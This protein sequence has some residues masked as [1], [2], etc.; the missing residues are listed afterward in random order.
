MI[1]PKT[2][3]DT[4]GVFL[5]QV[6]AKA[7]K[8]ITKFNRNWIRCSEFFAQICNQ[9]FSKEKKKKL[10]RKLISNRSFV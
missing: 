2:K 6:K 9:R 10:L 5:I 3:I 4:S 1:S 7:E 8:K